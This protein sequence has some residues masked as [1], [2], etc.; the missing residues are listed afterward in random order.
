MTESRP[1]L[2]PRKNPW[3]R[4]DV[5]TLGFKKNG[6]VLDHTPEYLEVRWMSGEGIERIPTEDIDNLL[7]VMHADSVSPGGNR[8]NLESLEAIE[9]LA[10][11]QDRITERMRTIK[12]DKE[13]AELD[14][15]TRRIFA[16]GKCRW[17]AKH[18]VELMLLLTEPGNVGYLFKLRNRFHLVFCKTV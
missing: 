11:I 6:F 17:D 18:S 12:S 1:S 5:C 3:K 8:T 2:D 14:R 10:R 7:R 16:D 9:T 15:L 13:R 4:G